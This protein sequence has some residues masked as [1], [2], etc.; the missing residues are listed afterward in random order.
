MNKKTIIT[1]L[2][3]LVAMMLVTIVLTRQEKEVK[4]VEAIPKDA[5]EQKKV[6]SSCTLSTVH[7]ISYS[8]LLI[9]PGS[10]YAQ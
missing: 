10:R 7:T 1:T 8:I 5:Q 4:S 6:S 9:L 2:L 3:A